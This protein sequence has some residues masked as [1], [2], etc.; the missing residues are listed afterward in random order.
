M[1]NPKIVSSVLSKGRRILLGQGILGV[2]LSD[3]RVIQLD[4]SSDRIQLLLMIQ[5]TLIK[6]F[7]KS[8][9]QSIK[10]SVLSLTQLFMLPL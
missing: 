2:V 4:D 6:A 3:Y 5:A 10:D 8:I 1:Y 7:E 9:V